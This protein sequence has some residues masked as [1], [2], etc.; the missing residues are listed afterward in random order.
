M[1]T[2]TSEQR[3][4][5][6]SAGDQPVEIVDPQTNAAFVLLRAEVYKRLCEQIEEDADL[7]IREAWGRLGQKVRSEWAKEDLFE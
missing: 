7:R 1:T 4:A 5:I 6:A 2:L 3:K